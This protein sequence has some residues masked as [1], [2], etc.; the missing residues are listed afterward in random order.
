MKKITW[1]PLQLIEVVCVVQFLLQHSNNP[2]TVRFFISYFAIL[3]G[4]LTFYMGQ[5]GLT[6]GLYDNT[7]LVDDSIDIA[8]S[9]INNFHAITDLDSTGQ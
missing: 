2:R 8:D 3:R 4:L 5:Q 1:D 9:F 6:I 7:V